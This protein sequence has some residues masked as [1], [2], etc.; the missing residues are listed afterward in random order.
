MP[1]SPP[2]WLLD[3]LGTTLHHN[4]VRMGKA[5]HE[6][7]LPSSNTLVRRTRSGRRFDSNLMAY[8]HSNFRQWASVI[9]S[10]EGQVFLH[11]SLP[12]FVPVQPMSGFENVIR[13]YVNKTL[14][15]SLEYDGD[16]SWILAGMLA[17]SLIII[18]DGSYMKEISPIIS[19]AATMIY[20]TIAK[21]RC[22]CTWTETSTSA[23]S[24][25]GEILGGVM[26]QLLLHAAATSYHGDIPPV[27]VDCDN[28]GVVFHGNNS[29]QPLSSNQCQA[30]LLRTFKNLVSTQKFQ[31]QYKY[32]TSHA[33][34]KKKWRDCS[35]KERINI[36][37]D[38]L[39]KKALKAGHSTGQYIES[40]FPNEQIWITL[41]G[42]KAIGPLR[43][44]LE[45]FWGRSTAKRFFHKKGIVSSS[46]FDS[47]WWS[48]YG[49]AI[50]EYPKPF[51]TFMT[52]Q[53]S[54]WCGCNSKLSLWED[55]VNNT[56]PQCGHEK[57][58]SKHLTRCTDPGRLLQLQSS[59]ET[60]MDILDSANVNHVLADMIETYLRNQGR[61]TMA[62]CTH[63]ASEFWH[64]AVN[65]DNLGWDC[66]IEGRIPISL[67]NTI[68][69]MLRRYKP[70]G[71]I[72]LWGCKLVKGLIGLT[73]KQ[74]L[75]RNN[76][77]HY[78]TD[79]LTMKQH[80]ELTTKIKIL[81][82]TR[83]CNL[84]RRHRHFLSTDFE[85]L[86]SGPTLARQVWVANMEMAISVAKLAKANFC[87]QDTLRQLNTLSVTPRT[88][89]HT[90]V[91][92]IRSNIRNP[93][94]A[95]QSPPTTPGSLKRHNRINQLPYSRHDT[96]HRSS[97]PSQHPTLFPI[98]FRRKKIPRHRT[99]NLYSIFYPADARRPDDKISTH[100]H[101]LHTRKKAVLSSPDLA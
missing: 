32:V 42:T 4:I 96:S 70:R 34:D 44:E 71:S 23:G 51:R 49:R 2:Q 12:C 99:P 92:S 68:K 57:E 7:Y 52:K 11:S 13:G 66:F 31:V 82:K 14:W 48:G 3:D 100:L 94:P 22:K 17:E 46:H 79:G 33:D 5:Y 18:H 80:E 65:I 69:P 40:S 72:K 93:L 43:S 89:P 83:H 35:L 53:V 78:V 9:L 50:S 10:Q 90:T 91:P 21:A 16:G 84:L 6:V 30:D 24:Y 75:F 98:F 19:S 97:T 76:E 59:I 41:G 38:R 15:A 45:D 26:T 58:T 28:N 87:S 25:R 29:I 37:V 1:H 77:I 55:T 8:S 56:C 88:Q 85:A 63:R 86:G 95:T 27:V 47:I 101:R 60:I 67:I 74:W 81:L 54:G 62:D 61:R 20:C 36:K 73:H 64:L 39:A